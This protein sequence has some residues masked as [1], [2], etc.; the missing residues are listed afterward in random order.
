MTGNTDSEGSGP[1]RVRCI[2][3]PRTRRVSC[4]GARSTRYAVELSNQG[5]IPLPINA[6][7]TPPTAPPTAAA[8][9][10]TTLVCGGLWLP[11]G[12]TPLPDPVPEPVPVPVPDPVPVP[13]PVPD[14][15]FFGLLGSSPFAM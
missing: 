15:G 1:Q 6:P 8:T 4:R 5:C 2:S 9:A 11:R 3:R 14:P 7:T 10:T 13:V 12:C